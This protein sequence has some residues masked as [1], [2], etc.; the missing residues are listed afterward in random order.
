MMHT[1]FLIAFWS[2]VI[3]LTLWGLVRVYG[4]I[5]RAANTADDWLT[6]RL[7]RRS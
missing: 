1:W 6:G 4:L 3:F 2:W 5:K 7:K